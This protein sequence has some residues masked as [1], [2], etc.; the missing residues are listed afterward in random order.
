[1]GIS[2]HPEH[3]HT[4]MG[5]SAPPTAEWRVYEIIGARHC[6]RT[7]RSH[8]TSK[9]AY[10]SVSAIGH[11]RASLFS[12][13]SGESGTRQRNVSYASGNEGYGGSSG[14]GG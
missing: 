11:R 5:N 4:V 3:H 7:L 6:H 2:S 12:V 1:M 14:S 9:R 8:V 10:L 13:E